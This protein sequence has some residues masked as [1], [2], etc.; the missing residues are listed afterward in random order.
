MDLD[1]T[2]DILSFWKGNQFRYLEVA[3]MTRDILSIHVSTI[4]LESTFHVGGLVIDQYKS[5]LK[6]D[7]VEALVC[8]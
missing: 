6:H 7:I 4:A 5:S 2:F 8:T 1:D 3:T